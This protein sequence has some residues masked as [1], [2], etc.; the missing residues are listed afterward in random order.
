MYKRITAAVF[1]SLLALSGTVHPLYA[2]DMPEEE[3]VIEESTEEASKQ[4]E[5]APAEEPSETEAVPV[6]DAPAEEE[7]PVPEVS[8]DAELLEA[9]GNCGENLTWTVS[10][11]TLTI[12][13]TGKMTEY[14]IGAPWGSYR[15]TVTTL[16]LNDGIGSISAYAFYNMTK[17]TSVTIPSS[18]ESVGS[19][20]FQ[21]CSSLKTANVNCSYLGES[22][23]ILCR[24]LQTVTI[25]KNVKSIGISA[26]EM[27]DGMTRVNAADLKSYCNIYFGGIHASPTAWSGHLYVNGSEVTNL[28]IPAGVKKI[29]DYA[30]MYLENLKTVTVP[31]GV[32]EIGDYAF[33]ACDAM[34]KIT[35]PAGLKRIGAHAFAGDTSLYGVSIPSSVNNIGMYAFH[36]VPIPS[37]TVNQGIIGKGAFY[38]CGATGSVSLGGNVTFIGENAFQGIPS[39]CD[40]YYSGSKAQYKYM[41]VKGGNSSVIGKI[42][43]YPGSG[44]VTVANDQITPLYKGDVV[45]LGKWNQNG[46]SKS[47]LLWTVLD[48]QGGKALVVSEKVLEYDIRMDTSIINMPCTWEDSAM[49]TYLNDTFYNQAFT[50]SEKQLIR[51]DTIANPDNS[52]FGTSGGND[53]QD[54]V[55]LLSAEEAEKYFDS[56]ETRAAAATAHA[57]ACEH[58]GTGVNSVSDTGYYWLRTPGL[59]NYN[60][61]YVSYE[62]SIR[63]DG[64]AC[65]NW[66]F[67]VRP[68]MWISTQ[69]LNTIAN[70]SVTDKVKAFVQRLYQKCFSRQSD[71]GGLNKWVNDLLSERSSGAS[72]ISGFFNSKEMQNLNLSNEDFVETCYQVMMNRAGDAGGKKD[73][74]SR[75]ENGVSNQHVLAGFVGS[76]EFTKI[77]SSYGI[78]RGSITLTQGRDKNAGIT[79]FVARC[80]TEALGRPYDIKGLN[81]W[82]DFIYGSSNRKATAITVASSGFFHSQEFKNK[83]TTNEEYVRILYRTFLGRDA[84]ESGF[85]YWVGNLEGG[86]DRDAVMMGFAKSAEFAKIMARYGIK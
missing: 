59:T 8:E 56:N 24:A 68:A 42:T 51:C 58:G 54:H 29:S 38:S 43:S 6:E 57:K 50:D 49:R 53:T 47:E 41:T 75:L 63:Y 66:V 19:F 39:I 26:F 72:V 64:A 79:A 48:V 76:A 55:F 65:A 35:L 31:A 32:T 3:A 69:G 23:F 84:D 44:K 45:R 25:G 16:V 71:V 46:S 74:V 33:Y 36:G 10:G 61:T 7:E 78:T 83:N 11:T 82:C 52:M 14:G 5:T 27:C 80:Y 60:Y 20:A 4:D 77:C 22:A 81:G 15:D 12:S 18:C 73:W 13:G 28:T 67:G 17:I 86:M 2:E 1:A 21:G 34:Q 85:S 37:V 40:V 70:R 30:F 9:S 62:G